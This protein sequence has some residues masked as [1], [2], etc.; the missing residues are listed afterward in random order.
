MKP[1]GPEPK[2]SEGIFLGFIDRSSEYIIG[3]PDGCVKTRDVKRLTD[4]DGRDPELAKALRG[5]PWRMIPASPRSNNADD[6]PTKRMVVKAEAVPR[7]QLP[8]ALPAPYESGPRRVYLRKGVE[9]RKYGYTPDCK[10]CEAMEYGLPTAGIPH[11]AECRGRIQREMESDDSGRKRLREADER[12]EA[13]KAARRVG[14]HPTPG[15]VGSSSSGSGHPA[16]SAVPAASASAE[17]AASSAPAASSSNQQ[18]PVAG[19]G[20]PAPA[21]PDA[22]RGEKRSAETQLTESG[23]KRTQ[24]ELLAGLWE[25]EGE[26]SE[27]LQHFQRQERMRRREL[28]LQMLSRRVEN[29]RR[30]SG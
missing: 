24:V 20:H 17:P 25:V 9:F 21:T 26:A 23:A 22:R 30:V 18:Q 10:A 16:P 19:S 7:E 15:D 12:Q 14:G 1:A 4:Q 3:T 6:I 5:K 13:A 2:W 8:K 29:G 28:T 27:T 11:T